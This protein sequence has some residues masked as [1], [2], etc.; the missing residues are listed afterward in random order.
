MPINID[1]PIRC[2]YEC[3]CYHILTRG[4]AEK[5]PNLTVNWLVERLGA[6]LSCSSI[7]NAI[8]IHWCWTQVISTKADNLHGY[9][10]R[11]NLTLFSIRRSS[12]HVRRT[13]NTRHAGDHFSGSKFFKIY[14]VCTFSVCSWP[15]RNCKANIRII[16]AWNKNQ[17]VWT[18]AHQRA[19][20]SCAC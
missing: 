16:R 2:I 10:H 15:R 8:P 12:H 6:P 11:T 5:T 9:P 18:R 7:A 1:I 3:F 13:Q 17:L 14:Q 20:R 4:R 19:K